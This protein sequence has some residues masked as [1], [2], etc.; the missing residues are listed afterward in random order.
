MAPMDIAIRQGGVVT[1]QQALGAG[2][3]ERMIDRRVADGE[4]ESVVL[5]VYRLL[6]A[7][8]ERDHLRSALAALQSAVV[9]HGSASR[10]HRLGIPVDA[11]PTVTVESKRTHDFPGVVVRRSGKTSSQDIATVAGLRCTTPVR[12]IIDLAALVDEDRWEESVDRLVLDGRVALER[13]AGAAFR[14]CGRGRAGSRLVNAYLDRRGRR[15]L[16][17]DLERRAIRLLEDSKIRGWV[18]EY[19]MPWDSGRRFDI[20]F[21]EL[22]LAVE[23]DSRT[24]HA[25]IDRMAADRARDRDAIAHGWVVVRFTWTDIVDSPSRVVAE[26]LRL[27]SV[28]TEGSGLPQG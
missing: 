24:W 7:L 13:L 26:I 18:A 25:S 15:V 22:R 4:W 10:L 19:P 9:S 2:F 8:D 1:R 28:R 23:W 11:S 20:A 17:S 16:R 12:T 27:V 6:P 3:S 5:G 14:L 21:P